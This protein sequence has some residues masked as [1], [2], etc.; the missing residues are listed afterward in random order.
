[1]QRHHGY[2]EYDGAYRRGDANAGSDTDEHA[3]GYADQYADTDTVLYA[4]TVGGN[5]VSY[6]DVMCGVW[7]CAYAG[8]AVTV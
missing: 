3:N 8:G 6:T 4:T 2:G 1:M 7:V 5:A